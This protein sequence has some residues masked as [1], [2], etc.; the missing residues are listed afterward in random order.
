MKTSWT[1][2]IH[3]QR[4]H[5]YQ[6]RLLHPAKFSITVDGVPKIFYDKNKFTQYLFRNPVLQ[7]IINGK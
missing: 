4:E 3:T 6:H 2:V 1:D 7:R 5:K